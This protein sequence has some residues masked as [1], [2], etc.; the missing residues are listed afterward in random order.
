MSPEAELFWLRLIHTIIFAACLVA[1]GVLIVFA[2]SGLW[3]SAAVWALIAPFA[4]LTGLILNGGRCVLQTRAQKLLGLHGR[5]A[6]DIFFLPESWAIRVVEV[7]APPFTLAV[8]GT[9]TRL[10]LT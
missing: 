2:V 6:R 3:R 7:L 10:A 1:L 4:I 5:W 9:L 8:V